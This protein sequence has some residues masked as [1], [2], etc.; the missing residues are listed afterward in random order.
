MRLNFGRGLAGIVSASGRGRGS[1]SDDSLFRFKALF[2]EVCYPFYTCRWIL[3]Q[4][5][6]DA[7]TA[8]R[9][10]FATKLRL[11][12]GKKSFSRVPRAISRLPMSVTST[13]NCTD[14]RES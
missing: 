3:D 8:E 14:Q 2:S 9:Q 11:G 7:L 10:N 5:I 4:E 12:H 13:S 1:R 6:Y